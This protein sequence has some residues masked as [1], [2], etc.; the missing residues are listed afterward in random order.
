MAIDKDSASTNQHVCNEVS[1]LKKI[2]KPH[3]KNKGKTI[4]K[5]ILSSSESVIN[6][7]LPYVINQTI[8]LDL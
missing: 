7:Q 5:S 6:I 3:G 4:D 8:E 1:I 2:L